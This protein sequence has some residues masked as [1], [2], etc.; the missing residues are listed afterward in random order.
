MFRHIR[1]PKTDWRVHYVLAL[2]KTHYNLQFQIRNFLFQ[3]KGGP[4]QS[5]NLGEKCDGK[6]V[7][8]PI[9][10]SPFTSSYLKNK[11]K[12]TNIDSVKIFSFVSAMFF[13]LK[14]FAYDKQF[15]TMQFR[16]ALGSISHLDKNY[17][18]HRNEQILQ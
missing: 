18:K 16:W 6:I 3:Q 7:P 8:I 2:S 11:R 12:I 1:F 15:T 13:I 10:R 17:S 5:K 4:V 9:F 14:S